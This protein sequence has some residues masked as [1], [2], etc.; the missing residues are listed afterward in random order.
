MYISFTE[1]EH[2]MSRPG[3]AYNMH[4]IEQCYFYQYLV[5]YL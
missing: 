5:V 3:F 4:I 2:N 1:H